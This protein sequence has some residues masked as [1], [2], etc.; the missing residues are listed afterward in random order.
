M[1]SDPLRPP[2]AVLA[3]V[4]LL[5][6]AVGTLGTHEGSSAAA[7]GV[8]ESAATSAARDVGAGAARTDLVDRATADELGSPP[9]PRLGGWLNLTST[10]GQPEAPTPAE[11]RD[12]GATLAYDAKDGYFVFYSGTSASDYP[13]NTW[14]FDHGSWSEDRNL[15][16]PPSGGGDSAEMVYDASDGYVVLFDGAPPFI[17]TPVTWVYSNGTWSNVTSM[18]PTMPAARTVGSLAYDAASGQVVLF[19]GDC[20]YATVCQDQPLNDTWTFHAGIWRNVTIRSAAQPPRREGASLLPIGADGV[21][22]FGGWGIRGTLVLLDDSWEFTNGT[23]RNVT[24]ASQPHPSARAL[25]ATAVIGR[26]STPALFGGTTLLGGGNLANDTWTYEHGAWANVSSGLGGGG[27]A[28]VP[29]VGGASSPYAC[30][31][32]YDAEDNFTLLLEATANNS[33]WNGYAYSLGP[34]ALSFYRLSRPTIDLGQ[35]FTLNATL[36]PSGANLSFAT[37]PGCVSPSLGNLSCTPTVT[38]P[39]E[40]NL[41]ANGSGGVLAAR[42]IVVQVN[43]DPS[44]SSFVLSPPAITIGNTTRFVLATAYGTPPFTVGYTGYPTGC[45]TFNSASVNCTPGVVG[46]FRITA[47]AQD[48][49]GLEA[50]ANATLVVN[51]RPTAHPLLVTPSLIDLGS[52]VQ[53]QANISDGTSPFSYL[54]FDLP[55]GCFSR[56]AANLTCTPTTAGTFPIA[57]VAT[58]SFGWIASSE[59]TL[60]V[61]PALNVSAFAIGPSPS[62]VGVATVLHATVAGGFAPYSALLSGFPGPCQAAG[63]LSPTCYP[64]QA[65]NFTVTLTVTDTLGVSVNVS[66]PLTVA[67][68]LAIDSFGFATPARAEVGQTSTATVRASGGIAPVLAS[69]S[70]LSGGDFTCAPGGASPALSTD[71]TW[72]APGNFS[73]LVTLSD[74]AGGAAQQAASIE[75]RTPPSVASFRISPSTADQGAQVDFAVNVTGGFPPYSIQWTGLPPGCATV[76]GPSFNCTPSTAGSYTV[77][78]VVLDSSGGIA[79]GSGTLTIVATLLGV[80]VVDLVVGIAIAVV[81]VAAVWVVRRRR[82]P[83]GPERTTEPTEPPTPSEPDGEGSV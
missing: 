78:A 52:A 47:W 32:A 10:L 30:C 3:V 38:G 17:L 49:V 23:W 11:I 13:T 43:P 41:S 14:I 16:Q 5:A 55:P 33:N 81:A 64:S 20:W 15:P 53:L 74:A 57:A 72:H 7:T 59:G 76:F 35:T 46:T 61:L 6:S 66:V 37:P 62:E 60:T 69:Y 28:S 9:V 2:F 44:I 39:F 12:W 19:G 48:S 77:R 24:N 82:S 79:N 36:I 80:P 63:S 83:R 4:L 70:S 29:L 67:P 75:V 26:S 8:A 27:P 25:S 68:A 45:G 40:V 34:S 58:D 21:L 22:L 56:D 50:Y 18:S 54:W 31:L 1:D 65:G 51:P 71:C 42:Q 73:V